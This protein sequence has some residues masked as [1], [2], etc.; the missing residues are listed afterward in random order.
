M[1]VINLLDKKVYNRISAGEVVERPASVVK[2][3]V[4]NAIDAGATEI[5]VSIERGGLTSISV[6]D[7][8]SGIQADQLEKAFLPHATSKIIRAEDLD[9]ILTL[10]FRGEALASIGSVSKAVIASKT[11]DS[12]M[13]YAISC[14]GGE[15]S[16]IYEYPTLN[17]TTVS[18]NE[19][20]FNTPAREKFLKSVKSEE[21]EVLAILT[22]VALSRPELSFTLI[23][24]G[25]TL[26]IRINYADYPVA[27]MEAN[28]VKLE[29]V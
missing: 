9:N 7:N 14:E 25:K 28:G 22:K 10:G 12:T 26:Q 3:L 24:D 8:G 13:G 6:K 5:F 4:E 17:G 18:V 21:G 1:A 19:L 15:L 11:A 29:Y 16:K 20:F 2:E 23:A 27:D